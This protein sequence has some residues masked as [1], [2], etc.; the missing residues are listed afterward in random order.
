MESLFK[1][2][3]YEI[4]YAELSEKVT[5]FNKYLLLKSFIFWKVV[6][7]LKTYMFWIITYS[8]EKVPPTQSICAEKLFIFEK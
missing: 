4:V 1:N 6:P 2:K 7:A 5:I 3:C 8:W